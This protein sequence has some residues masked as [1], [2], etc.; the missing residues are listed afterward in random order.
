MK[1][2]LYTTGCPM[3]KVLK[4]K[5]DSNGLDYDVIDDLDK[6]IELGFQSAPILDV[7]GTIMTF[8]EAV[9]WVNEQG[10]NN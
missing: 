3:C 9:K 1:I 7:D 6:M 4:S 10:G 2:T 5:L 8:Q